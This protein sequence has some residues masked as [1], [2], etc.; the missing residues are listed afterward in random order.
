LDRGRHSA[1]SRER[2]RLRFA[3]EQYHFRRQQRRYEF[4]PVDHDRQQYGQLRQQRNALSEWRVE[5]YRAQHEPDDAR[6]Q[7]DPAVDR[8]IRRSLSHR[9]GQWL[10]RSDLGEYAL[11]R[12]D[13]ERLEWHLRLW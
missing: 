10:R 7:H 5:Y 1:K 13:L 9:R 2:D 4:S 8:R 3:G 6:Q 12:F 11:E